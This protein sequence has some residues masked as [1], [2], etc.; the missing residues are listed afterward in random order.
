MPWP[1]LL[2]RMLKN[3]LSKSIQY[4]AEILHSRIPY[5]SALQSIDPLDSGTDRRSGYTIRALYF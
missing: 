5:S 2:S 3:T 1:K 4:S